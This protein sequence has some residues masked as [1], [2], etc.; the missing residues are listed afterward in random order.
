MT[1]C[2]VNGSCGY[3]AAGSSRN[4]GYVCLT[5]VFYQ[6]KSPR[7]VTMEN[8]NIPHLCETPQY[9]CPLRCVDDDGPGTLYTVLT[10]VVQVASL[11]NNRGSC[12]S[13]GPRQVPR[14]AELAFR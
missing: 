5:C 10:G 12:G 9:T 7:V 4:P 13:R 14:Q 6:H 3:G 2:V 8:V 11:G 1:L